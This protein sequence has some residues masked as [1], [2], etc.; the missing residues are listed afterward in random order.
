M[1]RGLHV[2]C[3]KPLGNSVEEVRL[4]RATYLRNRHKLATQCGTQRHAFENFNRVRELVRDGAIRGIVA[5]VLLGQPPAPPGR[6]PAG[7]GEPPKTLH[8]DLWIGRRPSTRTTP[9]TSP[10]SPA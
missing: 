8:Y 1:N 7:Q 5:R 4:V 3:E 6:L 9:T 2:F 10:G